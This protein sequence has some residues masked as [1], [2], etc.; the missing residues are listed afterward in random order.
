MILWQFYY[1]LQ[2]LYLFSYLPWFEFFYWA[3]ERLNEFKRDLSEVRLSRLRLCVFIYMHIHV[4]VCFGYECV[5]TGQ[6]GMSLYTDDFI[7][8]VTIFSKSLF[9]KFLSLYNT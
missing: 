2:L 6:S 9:T 7:K 1:M 4:Y 8:T 5:V 3:L